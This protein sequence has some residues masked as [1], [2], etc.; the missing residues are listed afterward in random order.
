MFQSRLG[1]PRVRQCALL[2]AALAAVLLP[3]VT[4]AARPHPAQ[5]LVERGVAEM[6]TNPDKSKRDAEAALGGPTLYVAGVDFSH[7]GPRFGDA[8]L[9]TETADDVRRVD[10][11]AIS[12]AATGDADAWF[13]AIAGVEDGTRICGFAPTYCMLRAATP[14]AGRPL[15]YAESPEPDGTVVTV[16]AV[17]WP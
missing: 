3:L 6:R 13:Q 10:E 1:T 14:G 16:A 17:A 9:D 12:A 2:I 4:L 5:A 11:L 15:A 7:V 8:K